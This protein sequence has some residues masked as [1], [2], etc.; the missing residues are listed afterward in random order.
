MTA[1]LANANGIRVDSALASVLSE[2]NGIFILKEE[3]I[4]GLKA[5]LSEKGI[6]TLLATGFGK[7]LAKR[8][9]TTHGH[10]V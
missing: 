4:T 7:S 2:L 9:S 8:R 1:S 3:Q 6:F 5:F 10:E